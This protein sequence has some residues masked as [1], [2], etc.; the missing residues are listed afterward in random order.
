MYNVINWLHLWPPLPLR[1]DKTNVILSQTIPND[2]IFR[3]G[4]EIIPQ[5]QE[6]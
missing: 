6:R 1:C 4:K 2:G 5:N 3:Y